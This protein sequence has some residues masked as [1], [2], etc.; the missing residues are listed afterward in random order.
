MLTDSEINIFLNELNESIYITNDLF[1][2]EI[3]INNLK[4]KYTNFDEILNDQIKNNY[5]I[6]NLL[7]EI[8][9]IDY[10]SM[11]N[12]DKIKIQIVNFLIY[13]GLEND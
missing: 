7:E 4:N 8:E 6:Q 11:N 9:D 1:K 12:Q 10:K 5:K 3:M 13:N 2:F